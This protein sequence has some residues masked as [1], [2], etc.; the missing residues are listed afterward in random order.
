MKKETNKTT[1]S[2]VDAGSKV[3]TT[4]QV[5]EKAVAKMSLKEEN[6]SLK[7]QLTK[8]SQ[9]AEQ[10]I[11]GI[12]NILNNVVPKEVLK[13][14]SF[15]DKV[16][17]FLDGK[18]SWV[19]LAVGSV[20]MI[21]SIFTG[22]GGDVLVTWLNTGLDTVTD[23][24]DILTGLLSGGVAGTGLLGAIFGVK[25]KKFNL[26]EDVKEVTMNGNILIK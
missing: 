12:G 17:I 21:L 15:L 11:N 3:P 26:Q 5:P 9:V 24:H 18:G 1:K 14:E 23:A 6:A 20:V 8:T 2:K 16:R 7:E 22:I 25:A 13:R 19:K 10:T 4:K